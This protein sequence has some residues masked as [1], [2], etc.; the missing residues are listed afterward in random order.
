MLAKK[1]KINNNFYRRC[2][3][4]VL[5]IWW[6]KVPFC[7]CFGRF[8]EAI[9]Q[10]Y[11]IIYYCGNFEGNG[12]YIFKTREPGPGLF[13]WDFG[14]SFSRP[15]SYSCA[16][17]FI[18]LKRILSSINQEKTFYQDIEIQ[19][20]SSNNLGWMYVESLDGTMVAKILKQYYNL[21]STTNVSLITICC[22]RPR[23]KII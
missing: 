22:Y 5:I 13:Y 1:K 7:N 10:L 9:W 15:S 23:D 19:I 2:T 14:R 20:K 4:S 6:S 16:L 17:S 18:Q 11:H 12:L 21:L 8:I 3:Y